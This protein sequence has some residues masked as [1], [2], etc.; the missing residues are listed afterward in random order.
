M[1]VNS[2]TPS[3]ELLTPI[4]LNLSDVLDPLRFFSG[5]LGFG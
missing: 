4:F 1:N 2:G 5:P 3:R